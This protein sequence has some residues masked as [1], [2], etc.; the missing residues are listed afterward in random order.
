MALQDAVENTRE[1]IAIRLSSVSPLVTL[2]TRAATCLV[3]G[4]LTFLVAALSGPLGGYKLSA[5]LEGIGPSP[6]ELDIP[7][8]PTLLV[9]LFC[10]LVATVVTNWVYRVALRFVVDNWEAD[11]RRHVAYAWS[12]GVIGLSLVFLEAA[13]SLEFLSEDLL[14]GVGGL[15]MLVEEMRRLYDKYADEQ[16][17][18][19]GVNLPIRTPGAPQKR[20]EAVAA[21]LCFW[22]ACCIAGGLSAQSIRAGS[23]AVPVPDPQLTLHGEPRNRGAVLH[24]TISASFVGDGDL[25]YQTAL[26]NDPYP[27]DTVGIEGNPDHILVEGLTNGRVYVFRMR[28]N[29]GMWSNEVNLVP[30]AEIEAQR[31]PSQACEQLGVVRYRRDVYRLD[32]AE[33]GASLNRIVDRLERMAGAPGRAVAAGYA[34]ARGRASYNLDL[35]ERRANGVVE[36]LREILDRPVVATAMGERHEE[37]VLDRGDE[38]NQQVVVTWCNR[39]PLTVGAIPALTLTLGQAQSLDVASYFAD[40]DG[41]SV[42]YTATSSHPGTLTVSV[43]EGEVNL[44]AVGNGRATVTVIASDGSLAATEAFDVSVVHQGA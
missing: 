11:D 20:L 33:N 4:E 5:V 24:W 37:A 14:I 42:S 35:S 31:P 12:S 13:S 36:H 18:D 26:L 16:K 15:N 8:G 25:E 43:T 6:K 23:Q 9:F 10:V 38:R 32:F 27:G 7:V 30:T 44:E 29:G 39:P 1:A 2:V 40:P 22:V 34:S 17:P 41:D 21:A 3:L 28:I 19:R